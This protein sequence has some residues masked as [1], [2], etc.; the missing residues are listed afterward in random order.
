MLE[1]EAIADQARCST[2]GGPPRA[3]EGAVLAA[4]AVR[5]ACPAPGEGAGSRVVPPPSG[6]P[7]T[8]SRPRA[9][10]S[11]VSQPA[12]GAQRFVPRGLFDGAGSR[13]GRA[14]RRCTADQSGAIGCGR[15][16]RLDGRSQ[17]WP[18]ARPASGSALTRPAFS[19]TLARRP[20]LFLAPSLEGHH[21]CAGAGL[22]EFDHGVVSRLADRNRTR[23]RAGSRKSGA[24]ALDRDVRW[25]AAARAPRSRPLDPVADQHAPGR[26]WP[27]VICEK[28]RRPERRPRRQEACRASAAGDDDFSFAR[29]RRRERRQAALGN[30]ARID[31]PSA[32]ARAQPARMRRAGRRWDRRGPARRR[33]ASQGGPVPRRPGPAWTGD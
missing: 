32:P 6:R 5:A 16:A 8:P 14:D 10:L 23:G 18:A 7:R 11:A 26:G 17:G 2:L 4:R 33:K 22:G 12:R 31:Q 21:H 15:A 29:A 9:E 30:I 24:G 3:P 1:R 13:L 28:A 19:S 27:P 25:S 20:L